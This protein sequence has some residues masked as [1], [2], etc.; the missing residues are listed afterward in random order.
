MYRDGFVI[1]FEKKNIELRI[2]D[3]KNELFEIEILRNKY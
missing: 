2:F 1:D 3:F